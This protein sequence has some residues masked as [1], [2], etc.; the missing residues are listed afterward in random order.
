MISQL[1]KVLLTGALLISIG[2]SW[3]C[4]HP[5]P[6]PYNAENAGLFL[7][8]G[9]QAVVVVDSL[10]GR[11]RHIAVN[12]NGDIYVKAR[13][14]PLND[15]YGN[16]ALRDTNG[17]GK[18]DIIIPFGQYNG[19]T[20][21]TAMRIH[22]GYLY[23]SSELMVY[24]MKLIPG[25]LLPDS[26]L[27]TIVIDDPPY[28][29]H[30]TK[31][32]AFDDKGHIFVGWGA[33][34]NA[35]QVNNRQPGSPGIGDPGSTTKGNPWL[36]DH[37]GIWMFDANKTNQH[38]SDGVRYATGLRSLVAL[39]WDPTSGS[40][41]TVSHGRDDLRMLWPDL[42]SPWQSAM[43]PAEEFFKI[44][45]G[46][47]GGWPYYYYDEIKE[48]KLLNPEFGG[49][50]VKAGDG[51]KLPQPILTFPAHFAPN[52][53]LFYKG[54]QFPAHY[55]N[56]AFVAFHGST[57]RA[58]YPQAG[59][60]IAFVPFKD[61]RPSGPWE[62][63]A[64][65]FARVDPI[66][67]VSDAVYRP[68][69]LSEGPDGSLYVSDTEKGRIWR[70]LYKGDKK[71]F[72]TAELA[73]M[74]KR[75]MTAS[76]IRTPD[77]KKDNLFEHSPAT[78]AVYSTYCS[79]CHQ[80]NGKGD[81]NRFPPLM[82]SEWVNYNKPR[83]IKVVLNGLSGPVQVKGVSYN[84]V[85]P[86]HGSFLSDSQVA[87]VL[88]Y[89]KSN[90]INLPEIVTPAEVNAVRKMLAA[91]AADTVL[92]KSSLFTPVN[93]F[94]NGVEGPAVD[95]AGNVYAVSVDHDGTI[96]KVTPDGKAGI[97]IE[98]P[99]GSIGN[100]IRFDS[101]GTM[102]IADYTR[103][104]IIKVD[105]ATKQQHIFVHEERMSQ[106]ND[107]AIDDKDRIYASD[108]NW[109]AG[110]GKIWRIDP[111]GK[112]TL[113]ASMGTVNGID[114]SPDNRTLY[115]NENRKIWAFDLSSKGQISRKRLVIEFTD[116]GLDGL[117]CDIKGNIYQARYGK[118]TV[119]KISPDGKIL[120]EITLHGKRP[121]NVAFGGPDGKTM[122]VTLQDQGNLEK[123]RVDVA[124]R[125]WQ[126]SNTFK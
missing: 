81:G 91:Q 45:E 104:N 110:T 55:K 111:D 10:K 59:Y 8:D 40:L 65:G 24:R 79:A 21:G 92:F 70:I 72:G 41:Y 36:K 76:N 93:S 82:Q 60:I 96:G 67:S 42:Y 107:I 105:M 71:T 51:A 77:E 119:V 37:G 61:G 108:P 90:F 64:D 78:S 30:Q 6:L 54:E 15:G 101:H 62:V 124:G 29:E 49:D 38:Q 68:M 112:V 32:I 103:H 47:D 26:K 113:L 1:L 3:N 109:K 85:M 66:L 69:G 94:T 99:K 98:L 123:F 97:F 18:A 117:R 100:G 33:G 22:D 44:N 87:E 126:M 56:G 63:F 84:E 58:P 121:T 31:P 53:L 25:Q 48:K 34:S 11:A 106:P 19:H 116:F 43:Q 20:Y 122:Y 102:L 73:A 17:D 50:Q 57:D 115:V 83:L 86:A 75:K 46:F 14:H 4:T 35:G 5:K 88:T 27:D 13:M 12:A 2:F 80:N 7:P 74:E 52:D 95:G 23:F 39:D 118:G 89:V 28:H 9:F 125:E 120:Q 16:I 114:V